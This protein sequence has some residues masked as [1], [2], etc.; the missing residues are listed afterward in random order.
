MTRFWLF[1]L[2]LVALAV[3][4]ISFEK[5]DIAIG[6]KKFTENIILGEMLADLARSTGANPLHHRELGGST[7]V[8]Q[9]LQKNAELDAYVDYTGTIMKELYSKRELG[10]IGDLKNAL[11]ADGVS[12]SE[13]LGFDNTYAISMLEPRAR[14]L[15]ITKISD[16][17]RYPELH[18]GFSNEFMDRADTWRALKST[19]GFDFKNVKGMDHD[20]AY[21]QLEAGAIDVIDAYSTDAKIKTMNLRVLEDDRQ[22]FPKYQ[23]VILYRTDLVKRHP[24]VVKAL[25]SLENKINRQQMTEMNVK[26]EVDKQTENRVATDF[27]KQQLGLEIESAGDDSLAYSILQTTVQHLDLVRR[28]LIPAILLGI[29]IGIFAQ[30]F[31][32]VGQI[33][34]GIIGIFQTIPALALLVLVMPIVAAIGGQALGIGSLAAVVALFLYS[35]LPIVRGTYVG[36]AGIENQYAE[37]ADALGLN[38]RYQLF[39]IELPL[40]MRSILSGIKTAAVMNVGFAAL[41][42]LIGAG[43]Y[44]QPI[45]T[46][47][48]LLRNDLILQGAIPAALLAIIVQLLFEVAERWVVPQGLLLKPS[49]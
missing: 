37:S 23:A 44:G 18:F 45:L 46:G 40:A 10:N 30:K 38:S 35:L 20:I 5:P 31:S 11:A 41:G 2:A 3:V 34:L 9:A 7:V 28:S 36:F 6:S 21:R 39:H 1:I 27:L 24:P 22:C 33:V 25:L 17:A 47:I 16:L 49:S 13:P 42:A 48:R 4:P 12:I 43:G 29:P 14:E 26:V 15:G 32:F 8:F 19:Y